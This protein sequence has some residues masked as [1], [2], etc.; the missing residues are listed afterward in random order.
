MAR[1]NKLPWPT[2]GVFSRKSRPVISTVT[3]IRELAAAELTLDDHLEARALEM[4]KP[5]MS[6]AGGSDQA[7]AAW[8]CD[9]FQFQGRS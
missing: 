4:G 8:A 6:T 9:F 2:G 7:A 5:P 3:G 1:A